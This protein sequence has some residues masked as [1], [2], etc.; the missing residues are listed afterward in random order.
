[1]LQPVDGYW[2]IQQAI[3]ADD[4]VIFL[5]AEAALLGE[6]DLDEGGIPTAV[7]PRSSVRDRPDVLA[8][9]PMVRL[10]RRPWPAPARRRSLEVIDLPRCPLDWPGASRSRRPA[11]RGGHEA[12]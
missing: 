4:P 5:R 9:G 2:M 7:Q 8:Y 12:T 11:R 6:G 1:V 10:P 3:A